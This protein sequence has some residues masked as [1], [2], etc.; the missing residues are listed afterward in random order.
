MNDTQGAGH[1]A[2]SAGLDGPCCIEFPPRQCEILALLADGLADKEIAARLGL[3]TRTIRTHLE[4]LYSRY[5]IHSRSAAVALWFRGGE[6]TPQC[7]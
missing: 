3:S 6:P 4:R 7:R 1:V 5:G 2:W